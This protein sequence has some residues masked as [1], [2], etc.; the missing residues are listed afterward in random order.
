M[1]RFGSI[2]CPPKFRFYGWIKMRIKAG[3]GQL[4]DKIKSD[5]LTALIP[6]HWP[7]KGVN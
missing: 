2:F 1:A 3:I 4:N 5:I 7:D 6:V